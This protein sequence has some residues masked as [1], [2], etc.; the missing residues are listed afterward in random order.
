MFIL[1]NYQH[2]GHF[3][4]CHKVLDENER[5]GKHWDVS[6]DCIPIVHGTSFCDLE[7]V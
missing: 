4:T 2:F 7:A 3:N 1:F 6:L 5:V